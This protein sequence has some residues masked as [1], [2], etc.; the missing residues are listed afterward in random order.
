MFMKLNRENYLFKYMLIIIFDYFHFQYKFCF[1]ILKINLPSLLSLLVY[2]GISMLMLLLNFCK[3]E[4]TTYRQFLWI[5]SL[6]KKIVHKAY[7][8]DF[9]RLTL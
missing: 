1:L 8:Q 3:P 9:S 6:S 4:K 7:L 5:C 2:D